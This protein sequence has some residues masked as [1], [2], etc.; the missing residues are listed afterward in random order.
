MSQTHLGFHIGVIGHGQEKFTPETERKCKCEIEKVLR[1][2]MKVGDVTVVSGHSPKCGVDLWA[3]EIA[4]QLGLQTLIFKPEVEQW[5]PRGAHGYKFRNLQIAEASDE[6]HVFLVT[7][8]P[9]GFVGMRFSSCYHCE[10]STHI[11]SGACWT[12]LQAQKLGKK[13]VWHLIL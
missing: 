4:K 11:K 2:A 10:S 1:E 8:Y 13:S 12:T 5:D 7:T 6:V 9:P 3:E